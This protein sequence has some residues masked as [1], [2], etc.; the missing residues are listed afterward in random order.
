MES[1]AIQNVT[2]EQLRAYIAKHH[3]NEFLLVDV[4]QPTEY[5]QDHIPGALLMPLPE[6]ES[7]LYELPADRDMVFYC[8]SGSRSMM[9]AI[10]VSE[11]EVTGDQVY[12]LRGGINAWDGVTLQDFPKVQVFEHAGS[13]PELLAVAMDLEKGAE[14]YYTHVQ[15]KYADHSFAPLFERLAKG[16]RA[17]ASAIFQFWKKDQTSPPRFAEFYQ[18]L[19][20]QV[21]EGGQSLDDVL[22]Q[23]ENI[24]ANPCLNLI[25]LSLRIEFAAFDLYRYLA[26]RAESESARH[27]FVSIA[28]AEKNHMRFLAAGIDQ[29]EGQRAEG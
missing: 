29:C 12:N 19:P 3:E 9:A 25:E 1:Q 17:H 21:L 4:R 14:R 26:H 23:I 5:Q 8:R 24:Q 7:R 16:E 27:A 28:Q 22:E 15:Q 10:L 6:L 20:G 18:Q 2:A 13:L 11:G